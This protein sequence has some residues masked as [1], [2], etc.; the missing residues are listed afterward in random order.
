LEL[1]SRAELMRRNAIHNRYPE[2]MV[3]AIMMLG[4]VK[5]KLRERRAKE[6][7]D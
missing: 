7:H 4:A 3:R 5:R 6:H 1:I 2:E